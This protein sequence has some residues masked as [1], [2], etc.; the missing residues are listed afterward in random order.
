MAFIEIAP[1]NQGENRLF[2]LVG[3]C[4]IAFAC[5]LSFTL[6]KGDY[7][8][9]LAFDVRETSKDDQLKLMALYSKKYK[10]LKFSE[11]TMLI[12]PEDGEA[13]IEKYLK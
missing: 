5:R 1:H 11:T 2:D 12:K 3:G 8:G 6:G 13:L 9:W 10:A 4:L 7:K